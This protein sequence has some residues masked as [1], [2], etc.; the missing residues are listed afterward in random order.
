MV[1]LERLDIFFVVI[2]GGDDVF[3]CCYCCRCDAGDDGDDNGDDCYLVLMGWWRWCEGVRVSV[4]MVKVGQ[5]CGKG[6]VRTTDIRSN[7]PKTGP[8]TPGKGLFLQ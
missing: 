4:A 2:G 1:S 5:S 6:N 3:V 7:T 8:K